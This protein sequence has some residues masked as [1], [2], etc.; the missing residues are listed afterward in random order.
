M[1]LVN[2]LENEMHIAISYFIENFKVILWNLD[3]FALCL[4]LGFQ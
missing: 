2:A 4:F 1:V 3:K